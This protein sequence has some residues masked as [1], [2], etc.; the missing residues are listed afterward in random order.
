MDPE[1][2]P[3]AVLPVQKLLL[4]RKLGAVAE[5]TASVSPAPVL[6]NVPVRA[7]SAVACRDKTPLLATQRIEP[8]YEIAALAR[9]I[10]RQS[11]FV[12]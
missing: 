7:T 6:D 4:A 10:F 2:P 1:M 9:K 5:K 8:P 3:R 11:R 12:L